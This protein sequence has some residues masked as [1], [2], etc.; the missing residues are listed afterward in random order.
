MANLFY[1]I[2]NNKIEL[3][4][5]VIQNFLVDAETL[6]SRFKVDDD[7]DNLRVLKNKIEHL[8]EEKLKNLGKKD[9]EKYVEIFNFL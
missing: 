4:P 1:E 9:K 7:V 6:F 2:F 5:N 8:L 3:T